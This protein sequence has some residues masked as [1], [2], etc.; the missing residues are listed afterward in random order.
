MSAEYEDLDANVAAEIVVRAKST[1][2][3]PPQM[4]QQYP[5]AQNYANPQLGQNVQQLPPHHGPSQ[6]MNHQAVAPQQPQLGGPP[7]NVANLI[8]SL[9]G[10]SLQ[11][12]LSSMAQNQQSPQNPMHPQAMPPS[13]PSPDLSALLS[14][15]AS[16]Q[17]RPQGGPQSPFGQHG[18]SPGGYPPYGGNAHPQFPPPNGQAASPPIPNN[19]ALSQL[20]MSTANRG[21]QPGLQS[22]GAQQQQQ[23]NVQDIMTQLA[24]YK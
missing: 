18:P 5:P 2:A 13:G 16:Q 12:L 3:A 15:V 21:P 10:P 6:P 8:T 7:P 14:S 24:R 23:Q 4:R 17:H 20:L 11:K 22:P 9:D 1:H 19:T